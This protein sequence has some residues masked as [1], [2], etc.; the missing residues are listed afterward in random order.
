MG[1]KMRMVFFL[2]EIRPRL[3]L[4]QSQ[5]R[6][7]VATLEEGEGKINE[8]VLKEVVTSVEDHNEEA[9][10]AEAEDRLAPAMHRVIWVGVADLAVELLLLKTRLFGCTW[11]SSSKR[12]LYFLLAS[13][14]SQR[15]VARR[16]LMH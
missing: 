1:G 13:L 8:V 2:A 4:Q 3:L 15:S 9:A 16:M 12:R 14:F 5:V 7:E 11:S 10:G 6:V